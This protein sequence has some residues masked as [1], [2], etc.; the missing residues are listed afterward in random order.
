LDYSTGGNPGGDDSKA[1]QVAEQGKQAAGHAAAE[2]KDT[3]AEQAQKT[4][5]IRTKRKTRSRRT[6]M[7]I[8]CGGCS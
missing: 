4:T 1:K 3:A 6:R 5:K 2:V 8:S 7:E